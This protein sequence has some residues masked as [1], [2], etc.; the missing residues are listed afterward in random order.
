MHLVHSGS[1]DSTQAVYVLQIKKI[2]Q[3]SW[4][5]FPSA[6]STTSNSSAPMQTEGSGDKKPRRALK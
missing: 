4:H 2:I 6:T 1:Q 5:V 3:D